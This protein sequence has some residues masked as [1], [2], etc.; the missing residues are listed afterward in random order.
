MV[1]QEGLL[2]AGKHLPP[3]R[4]ARAAVAIVAA[5]CA[6]GAWLLYLRKRSQ[7]RDSESC[8]R[9]T[10]LCEAAERREPAAPA[11]NPRLKRCVDIALSLHGLSYTTAEGE[12]APEIDIS[13]SAEESLTSQPSGTADADVAASMAAAAAAEA[14]EA[15]LLDGL[16]AMMQTA[17][18]EE[19]PPSILQRRRAPSKKVAAAK[20]AAHKLQLRL[21]AR[22]RRLAGRKS[23]VLAVAVAAFLV[24]AL[25]LLLLAAWL[26]VCMEVRATLACAAAILC[27]G[28]AP[29]AQTGLPGEKPGSSRVAV[30]RGTL[31]VSAAD[32]P[33]VWR[34]V[35]KWAAS[36]PMPAASPPPS[37]AGIVAEK[38]A[39]AP[40]DLQ[41]GFATRGAL[42]IA[43]EGKLSASGDIAAPLTA[44]VLQPKGGIG[45]RGM[46][47]IHAYLVPAAPMEL[48][49]AEVAVVERL[50]ELVGTAAAP[51]SSA[52]SPVL[53]STS[54]P[55][56]PALASSLLPPPLPPAEAAVPPLLR[57]SLA[58]PR[59]LFAEL[60]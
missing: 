23:Q 10:S 41:R 16:R 29:A 4:A 57:A 33:A 55:P 9:K 42:L 48:A 27:I 52:S 20:S 8:S 40:E 47:T 53:G 26:S 58:A 14:Q 30:V 44:F 31:E 19:V 15:G 38:G 22:A 7:R 1:L 3:A 18:S 54:A 17:W 60:P 5:A 51:A 2:V 50:K 45:R 11:E 49:Q 46:M 28:A 37:G 12:G 25:L 13:A 34:G 21:P 43:V 24:L 6:G 59:P 36:C 35:A 32:T 56:F 39:A